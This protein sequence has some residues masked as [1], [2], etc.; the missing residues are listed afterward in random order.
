MEPKIIQIRDNS[1]SLSFLR[2]ANENGKKDKTLRQDP[3]LIPW[4]DRIELLI[5]PVTET[6]KRLLKSHS[7][8]QVAV[9]KL[10]KCANS[11]KGSTRDF[12]SVLKR[13]AIRAD[14]PE[15]LAYYKMP[16][17]GSE[18][19]VT[20]DWYQTALWLVEGEE[21]AIANGFPAMVNPS[22][23]DL[24]VCMDSYQQDSI[25]ADHADR[26]Y[27]AVQ[28]EM[29]DLRKQTHLSARGLAAN[30]RLV[31]EDRDASS[32]RRTLRGFGFR[33]RG[34]TRMDE[35]P[36]VE[37]EINPGGLIEAAGGNTQ[38]A[39]LEGSTSDELP[40]TEVIHV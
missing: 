24:Q 10:N 37:T 30:I 8:R 23:A 32:V 3:V 25:E 7:L 5:E 4:F 38:I 29:S 1:G 13:S 15:R 2:R 12:R 19:S 6:M 20:E 21:A 26:E 18:S 35:I 39:L 22:I 9:V 36:E 11:L 14:K 33:F 40:E 31:L 34:E 27:Q 28:A 16:N 17:K